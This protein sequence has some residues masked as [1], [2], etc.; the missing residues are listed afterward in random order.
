MRFVSNLYQIALLVLHK[1]TELQNNNCNLW[2]NYVISFTVI[3]LLAISAASSCGCTMTHVCGLKQH[4][5]TVTASIFQVNMGWS[6]VCPNFPT[7]G[8]ACFLYGLDAFPETHRASPALHPL[9]LPKGRGFT[10]YSV[11]RRLSDASVL[12]VTAYIV[13]DRR[14]FAVAGP[15][16]WKLYQ[17]VSGTRLSAAAASG[18]YL[19]R[20]SSTVTQHTQRSRDSAL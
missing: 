4:Y 6:V 20:T 3:E 17:T 8:K 18:N 13:V 11:G 7:E 10:P 5:T 12:T 14:A 15:T 9:W 19:R 16:V 2:F 1:V